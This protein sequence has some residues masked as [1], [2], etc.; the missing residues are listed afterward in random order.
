MNTTQS[1]TRRA[2]LALMAA[3]AGA[4]LTPATTSAALPGWIT[5]W[6]KDDEP[7]FNGGFFDPPRE[8]H[9]FGDAK[10]QHGKSF[11]LEALTGKVVFLYFGYTNCPDACPATL[12]EWREVKAVLKDKADDVVFAMVS[13]DPERDTPE[14]IGQYVEFWDKDFIGISMSEEQTAKVCDDWGIL[15]SYGEKDET[16]YYIVNHDVSTYV[17]DPAGKLRLTYPLGFDPELIKD[18]VLQLLDGK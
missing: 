1:G 7:T 2:F 10:D 4:A 6:E 11:S 17:V 16:G 5:F 15:Y 3:G 14:I 18:D 9:P 13:V 12:A 8:A